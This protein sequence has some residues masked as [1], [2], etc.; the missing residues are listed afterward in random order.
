VR[1]SRLSD[2]ASFLELDHGLFTASHQKDIMYIV[3]CTRFIAYNF[4]IALHYVFLNT[5][6]NDWT[7]L[8]LGVLLLWKTNRKVCFILV[9]ALQGTSDLMICS[10]FD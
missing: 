10:T 1:G 8:L 7:R 9:Q 4:I 5:K 3:C 6:I 2:R